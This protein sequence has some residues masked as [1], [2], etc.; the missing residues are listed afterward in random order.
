MSGNTYDV[1]VV[2]GGIMGACAAYRAAKRGSRVLLLEQFAIGHALGSSHGPH[3]IIRLAYDTAD[4]V[5]LAK[6]AYAMW[7]ELEQDSA[8]SLLVNVGGIDFGVPDALELREIGESYA[9]QGIA[10]ESLDAAEIHKRYPQIRPP[11][12]TIGFFQPDYSMLAADLCVKTAAAQAARFG[13][14]VAE[15][16]RVLSV[17]PDSDGVRV[18]TSKG[19]YHAARAILCAGSWMRPM[20]RSLGVDIPLI[21]TKE[22]VAFMAARDPE[23]FTIGRFPLFIHRFVGTTQLGSGFPLWR[24][25]GPKLMLDR[26][27]PVVDPDDS[28][29]SIDAAELDK[30]VTYATDL[31]PGLTGQVIE[32]ASCRYTMTPDEDFVVDTHPEH[33]QIVIASPCSGHGFKFGAVLG[34][35]LT[36]LALTGASDRNLA[37]F[38]LERFALRV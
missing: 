15:N 16:E 17:A 30:L 3:R 24:H 23:A 22:Q 34:D 10:F 19:V 25:S 13:A 32:T 4:Y 28:D 9:A 37:R 33:T 31:L 35:I 18:A 8:Q 5:V 14:V 26:S 38:R 6:S 20:L 21:V 1:I 36:D 11:E 27:G 29:R 12:G 2:G 7:H